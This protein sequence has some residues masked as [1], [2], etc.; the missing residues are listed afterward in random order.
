VK[1]HKR[2]T[3]FSLS[4]IKQVAV[5]HPTIP[6][7]QVIKSIVADFGKRRACLITKHNVLSTERRLLNNNVGFTTS[8]KVMKILRDQGVTVFEYERLGKNSF[9]LTS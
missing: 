5:Y 4:N 8:K 3:G 2:V 9:L 1:V 7:R 6:N